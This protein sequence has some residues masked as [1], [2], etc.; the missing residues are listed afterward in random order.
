[1][2]EETLVSL[3]EEQAAKRKAEAQLENEQGKVQKLMMAVAKLQAILNEK[4]TSAAPVCTSTIQGSCK[5]EVSS[6]LLCTRDVCA[7]GHVVLC[8][9]S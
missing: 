8:A 4:A 9:R 6:A 7:C 1:M 5:S 3:Q 2:L